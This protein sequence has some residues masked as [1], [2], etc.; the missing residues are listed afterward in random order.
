[1]S[2]LD[3]CHNYVR[4]SER[5]GSRA[6]ADYA[7]A[8]LVPVAVRRQGTPGTPIKGC[9]ENITSA[10]FHRAQLAGTHTHIIGCFSR[11]CVAR[12]FP[13]V[14]SLR[15]RKCVSLNFNAVINARR[16]DSLARQLSRVAWSW[17]GT[18]LPSSE[19]RPA[20]G[21]EW[22]GYS[23]ARSSSTGSAHVHFE[24]SQACR[25]LVGLYTKK[26]IIPRLYTWESRYCQ[27]VQWVR[28]RYNP[29][30]ISWTRSEA[31][32]PVLCRLLCRMFR[33]HNLISNTRCNYQH[34]HVMHTHTHTGD[35]GVHGYMYTFA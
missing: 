11:L 14:R 31:Y 20:G 24:L 22:G 2:A 21:D 12:Q 26:H 6:H 5:S 19:N 33:V 32:V 35:W 10:Y 34:M 15:H 18:F 30:G 4:C 3:I 16:G 27:W 17:L 8:A 9:S 1:M 23:S 13:A 29:D 7:P 28:V 25:W